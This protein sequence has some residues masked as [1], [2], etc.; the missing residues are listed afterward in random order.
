MKQQSFLRQEAEITARVCALVPVV[1][2]SIEVRVI[3]G[4]NAKF[5]V[6]ICREK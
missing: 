4:L 3:I 5:L 6:T 1:D 2:V